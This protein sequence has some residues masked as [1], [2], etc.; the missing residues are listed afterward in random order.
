MNDESTDTQF[1]VYQT[2]EELE[3]GEAEENFARLGTAG[4]ASAC[5][6]KLSPD[7]RQGLRDVCMF[8]VIS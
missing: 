5:R 4:V 1:L 6:R 7:R 2:N 8:G 3:D